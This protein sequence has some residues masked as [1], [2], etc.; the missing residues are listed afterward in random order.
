MCTLIGLHRAVPGYDLVI[1]MNRDEDRL[2]PAEPPQR[3]PG[4]PP[5]VAP[6]DARAGGTWLGVNQTGLFAALSNRRGG[7]ANAA[8]SRGLLVLDVL[9]APHVK[10]AQIALEREVAAHAYNFFNL[11]A[12]TRE[13]IRFFSYDGQLRTTRGHEGLNVMTNAGGNVEG[14]EKVATIRWLAGDAKFPGGQEAITWLERTLRHHG[15]QP[16]IAVGRLKDEHPIREVVLPGPGSAALCVHLP[17]G[18]TVSST[19]LALHN[20][21]PD[22]HVLL[23]ASGSPCENPYRAYSHILRELN[24]RGSSG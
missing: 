16:F 18:G 9:K 3:L 10:A 2:R 6:K 22:Q 23:Y 8:R 5:L 21:D 14:D 17:G 1:G 13:E 15:G 24:P 19:I 7:V 4:P 12:A 20:G 11:V